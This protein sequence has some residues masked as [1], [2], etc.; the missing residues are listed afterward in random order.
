MC[1]GHIIEG[2]TK[3]HKYNAQVKIPDTSDDVTVTLD[4][5]KRTTAGTVLAYIV[6]VPVLVYAAIVG[7][8]DDEQ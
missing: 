7:S 4:S 5:K 2:K 8:G 6:A 3:T 1:R